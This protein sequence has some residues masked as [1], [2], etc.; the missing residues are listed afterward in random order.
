M[1][2]SL[3]SLVRRVAA[4]PAAPSLD[5]AFVARVR[6]RLEPVIAPA[7]FVFTGADAGRG[8]EDRPSAAT[9]VRFAVAAQ[10]F[11]AGHPGVAGHLRDEGSP[12][13]LWAELDADRDAVR[14]EFESWHLSALLAV[15]RAGPGAPPRRRRLDDDTIAALGPEAALDRAAELLRR[16]FDAASPR[17]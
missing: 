5:D 6:K 8:D 14:L 17:R 9:V 3:R 7:G 15:V 1:N 4:G 13:E 12:L 2:P 16:L 10:P 11:V